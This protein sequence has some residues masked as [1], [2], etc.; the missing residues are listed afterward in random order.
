MLQFLFD[1]DHLTLYHHRHPP[2]MQHL[3]AHPADAVGISPIS[4]EETLRGRLAPLSR[5]LQGVVHVQ[6]YAHLMAAVAM[7][8][9]FPVVPFDLTSE[10]QFQQLRAARLRVRTQD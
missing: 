4:V 3:T 6:A 8:N 1:T 10:N 7:V 5:V 2:L 9:L